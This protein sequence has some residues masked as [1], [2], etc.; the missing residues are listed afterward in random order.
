MV[1]TRF[2]HEQA[3]E[4]TYH[5]PRSTESVEQGIVEMY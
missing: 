1:L 5:M 4:K 2:E 3:A